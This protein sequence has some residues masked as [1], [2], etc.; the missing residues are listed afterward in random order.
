MVD[1][2]KCVLYI[3]YDYINADTSIITNGKFDMP[4]VLAPGTEALF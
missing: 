1:A 4:D 3:N 2:N